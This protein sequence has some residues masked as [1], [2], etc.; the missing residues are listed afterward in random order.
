MKSKDIKIYEVDLYAPIRDFFTEEGYEVHGEVKHCDITAVKGEELIIVELKKSLT[1]DLLVQATKRQRLTDQVYIAIP[2]P[3]YNLFSKKWKD[4][5]HLIKRLELGLIL[6]NFSDEKPT[7]KIV[8]TPT[9]FDRLKTMQRSKKQRT[10]LFEET[11]GR[12]GDHNIGGSTKTKIITAYKENCIHVAC[13]LNH[14]GPMSPKKLRE[15]GA[16]DKV[17][18]IFQSNY[19]GWFEKISRGMYGISEVGKAELATLPELVQHYQRMVEEKEL[20]E[21]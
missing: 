12:S 3:K 19:Y 4:I 9:T 13:L 15:F 10:K 20:S 2:K 14:H 7:I 8:S 17:L 11:K 1:I 21:E 6:V 16:G 18:S 5:L